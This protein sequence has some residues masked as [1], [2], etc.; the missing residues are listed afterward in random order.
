MVNHLWEN[1]S[2]L[3]ERREGA[4]KGSNAAS[5]TEVVNCHQPYS[6]LENGTYPL[7][8]RGRSPL[9]DDH[10]VVHR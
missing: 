9:S 4:N 3:V 7:V 1:S 10:V 6:P 2:L 5:G 8:F